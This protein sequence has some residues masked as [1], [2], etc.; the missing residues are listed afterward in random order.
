[1][2]LIDVVVHNDIIEIEILFTK[3]LLDA[4]RFNANSIITLNLFKKKLS[5]ASKLNIPTM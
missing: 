4:M 5:T 3:V 1:M 2:I